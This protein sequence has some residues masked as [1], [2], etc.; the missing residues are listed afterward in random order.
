MGEHAFAK[1][2]GL[3][4][5]RRITDMADT[6]SSLV[7]YGY[8]PK[9]GVYAWTTDISSAKMFTNLSNAD[10]EAEAF[11]YAICEYT[12]TYYGVQIAKLVLRDL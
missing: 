3:V 2:G 10:S 4:V 1:F 12:N 11:K 9:S 8:S 7:L 5:I 6:S